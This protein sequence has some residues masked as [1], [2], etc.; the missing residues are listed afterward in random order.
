MGS[1]SREFCWNARLP[2]QG[3]S[4]QP[5][6]ASFLAASNFVQNFRISEFGSHVAYVMLT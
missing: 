1:K 4:R 6:T 3:L 5:T 2:K